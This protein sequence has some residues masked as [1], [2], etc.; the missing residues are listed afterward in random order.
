MIEMRIRKN[1][2]PCK[3][4]KGKAHSERLR[5]K[6]TI[7]II[8]VAAVLAAI[9][10]AAHRLTVL[11]NRLD[12]IE[13]R[14][15]TE[16]DTIERVRRSVVLIIGGEAEGSGFA[17]RKGG[18]IVTNFHVIE[19]EPCPKVVMPDGTFETG[20]VIMADKDADVAL[21]KIDKDPPILSMTN[22]NKVEPAEELLAIGYALGGGLPGAA[23]TA[24]GQGIFSGCRRQKD[25]GVEYVQTNITL[26]P[27]MSGGPMVN[28][29]G[30]VVG[31]NTAGFVLGGMGFAISSDTI[32]DKWKKMAG[33]KDPI[34][35]VQ[36]IAFLPQAS[37]LEAVK[38]FYNYLK[39]RRMDK[40][41]G[42][43]SQ[44]FVK[45]YSI[46][47]WAKGYEPLLDTSILEI[48]RDK[49]IANRI[50]VKISTKD[51]VDSE[52][53]YK[54]FEGRWDVRK[55]NGKWLLWQPKIKEVKEPGPKWFP[56][57]TDQ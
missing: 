45:G 10:C 15:Y 18:Y 20:K 44:H 23:Q 8:A 47:Q 39:V 49:H 28:A 50:L 53:M 22:L 31:M 19:F 38:A 55:I 29:G 34:K 13:T 33:A 12:K 32:K 25:A 52:V 57:P 41:F 27:G 5:V 24:V 51:L 48:K 21:I 2:L 42:L 36:K 3:S 56:K 26:V 14:L 4:D 40:A 7:K 9:A 37:P 1:D 30:E 43:L 46:E 6:R 16:K 54:Y 17:I 11:S 35:D